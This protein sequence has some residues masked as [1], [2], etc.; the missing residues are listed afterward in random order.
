MAETGQ[1]FDMFTGELKTIFIQIVDGRDQP[2]KS[3]D[4]MGINWSL[5]D[6]GDGT[7]NPLLEKNLVHG[8]DIPDEDPFI[9]NGWIAVDLQPQDTTLYSAGSYYQQLVLTDP[10]GMDFTI[11]TGEIYMSKTRNVSNS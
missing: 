11:M 2:I 1:D 9:G 3:F 6:S 7:G 8:I 4:G 5:W 10:V